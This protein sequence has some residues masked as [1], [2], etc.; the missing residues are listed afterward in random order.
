MRSVI[1]VYGDIAKN[2]PPWTVQEE[3]EFTN[4]WFNKDR[5]KWV[6]E[7]MKHNMSLVFKIFNKMSFNRNNEDLFQ[8]AVIAM[9]DALRKYDPK[10]DVRVCTWIMNPIRWAI[11]RSRHA[12]NKE[13]M[14]AD[15]LAAKNHRYNLGLTTVS[16]DNP[17]SSSDGGDKSETIGN[18]ISINNVDVNYVN[19]YG[20]KNESEIHDENEI[21]E[22]VSELVSQI[23]DI[24]NEKEIV[25][26]KG[27]LSG[28]NMAEISTEMSVSRVRISQI[29]KN[30]FEK[31]RRSSIGRKL[32]SLI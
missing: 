31:I 29:S 22:G 16:I 25:V 11:H 1:D 4:K 9:V 5:D 30:A 6:N 3:A 18:T 20:M 28:R 13:G 15:E 17:I 2:N 23:G 27:L 21:K 8:K 19:V 24:L 12:Y 10:K 32:K 14:I 7:A 26:I